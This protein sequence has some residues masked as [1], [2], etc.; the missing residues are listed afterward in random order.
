MRLKANQCSVHT[1]QSANAMMCFAC[2]RLLSIYFTAIGAARGAEMGREN[3]KF[4][5]D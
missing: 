1:S 2:V 3:E 4:S 5:L